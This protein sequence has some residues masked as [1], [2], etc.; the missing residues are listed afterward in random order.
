MTPVATLL[1]QASALEESGDPRRAALLYQEVLEL[2][3]EHPT[4]KQQLAAAVYSYAHILRGR[5]AIEAAV[6]AFAHVAR[7][8]PDHADAWLALGNACMELEM[9]RVAIAR[10]SDKA[11][12]ANDDPLANA[13]YALARAAKLRH[14]ALD[15]EANL[16]MAARYACAWEV[17]RNAEAA[18]ARLANEA[19]ESFACE[20]MTAITLLDDATLVRHGI[21]AWTRGHLP[22][23]SAPA[24][25]AK[26]GTRLRVG[27]LST[28]LHDHATAHLTAGMFELHDRSRF[29]V[30]AYALDRDDGSAMRGRLRNAFEH[31]RDLRELDDDAA[32][33]QIAADAIDVLIDLK[34]HTHG[35][36]LGIL[37][38]RPARAQLHYLGFPG[39]IAYEG[40]DGLVADDIVAPK[41]CDDEFAETLW[42][43]PVC[44]QVNDHRREL[45]A[46]MSR[47]EAG[48]PERGLVLA[49]FNQ[50]FKLSEA[51][52][53]TWLGVLRE[54]DDAVLWLNVPHDLAR[55]NLAALALQYGVLS[56]RIVFAP[57]LPHAAHIARLQCAD[58]AL[59][60]LPYGS[61]TTGSDALFA[62]VPL[63]TCRG[64]TFAGRV[65]ASLCTA[66]GVA[67]LVTESLPAYASRLRSLCTN[68]DELRGYKDQLE[69]E[70]SRL[71]LFD[72]ATFTRAFERVLTNAAG[73]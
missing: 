56:S 48:L 22:A 1:E 5:G 40:V 57:M 30:F 20:P 33:K 23:V 69:R 6:T 28:D 34:G 42:R 60:V 58:L 53:A 44:Y 59:D 67:D 46:A 70:R 43:L 13:V 39:T 25:I 68:R 51:F 24:V 15:I 32:V 11:T 18:I 21:A 55:R 63:L 37:A 61:H 50:T 26:R 2:E 10:T 14:D 54:H 71:P 3:P 4:A 62:G 49:S 72:T 73:G 45:P 9:Q 19:R 66:A 36:R 8:A 47:A 12:D 65:G 38:R 29:E 31:W 41:G 16:A 27:Y 17:S 35:S 64:K 7:L 52:V